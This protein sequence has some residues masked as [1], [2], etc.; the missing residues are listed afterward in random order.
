MPMRFR[1]SSGVISATSVTIFEVPMSRADEELAGVAGA[2]DHQV[3][4]LLGRGPGRGTFR[5]AN[6]FG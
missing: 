3:L 1:V 4:P 2:V 5:T 6:P